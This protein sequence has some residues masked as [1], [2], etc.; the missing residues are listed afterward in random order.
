[1]GLRGEG[2]AGEEGTSVSSKWSES[3]RPVALGARA[4]RVSAGTAA[5]GGLPNLSTG[6]G[7]ETV[8]GR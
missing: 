5:S 3:I 7:T 6:S 8:S 4:A 2:I 1:V